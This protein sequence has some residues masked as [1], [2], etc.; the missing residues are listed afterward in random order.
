MISESDFKDHAAEAL[1]D[2][3][4][5]VSPISEELEFEVE[6]G[7]GMLTFDFEKPAA[8]KFII[9]PNSPA[10]QIWVSA[11]STSFKFD[12]D[13]EQNSFVLDKTREH[14]SKVI[15]DLLSRQLGQTI[16]L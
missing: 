1:E 7:G 15:A 10:R 12:W 2:L 16:K 4:D 11:L 3:E 8:S 14:F 6:S 9:S 13:D 5:R